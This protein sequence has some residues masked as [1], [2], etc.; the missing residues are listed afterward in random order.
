MRYL[1]YLFQGIITS[2]LMVVFLTMGLF[3]GAQT[4]YRQLYA[5]V[6]PDMSLLK[7]S[8]FPQSSKIYAKNGELLYEFSREI[9]RSPVALNEISPFLQKAVVAIEDKDFYWHKGISVPSIICSAEMNFLLGKYAF[10]G[11]T[12]TQQVVK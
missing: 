3:F 1:F 2:L 12:I 9:K 6:S 10:G 5:V 8:N 7:E 11:S 4:A